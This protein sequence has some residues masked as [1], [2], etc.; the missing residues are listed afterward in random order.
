MIFRKQIHALVW[1][2]RHVSG[3]LKVPELSIIESFLSPESI[4][5]DVGAHGGSWSRALA[6]HASQR[7]VY[8]FEALPYYA[9]VLKMTMK[10]VGQGNLTILNRAVSETDGVV[11]MT[12]RDR[13]GNLLTGKTHVASREE[14]SQDSVS[15]PA[16]SLD[17]FW[18]EIGEKQ[19]DFI[20]CDVEGFELF[21]LR[22]ARYL[23][24]R[25]RPVFYN[26]LNLEWCKRYDYL[27]K[28]IFHL[29][30]G[31][32]YTPFYIEPGE[33]LIPVNTETHVNRDVLFV[34]KERP[35]P[36]QMLA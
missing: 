10:L 2:Y 34:P 11:R 6:R 29:F 8:A 24:E 13:K 27:P 19:V 18:R 32:G 26:E 3:R 23:I 7:R 31:Y 35:I 21:I 28:D 22:G 5:F 25:C 4:C 16:V 33:G 20:K 1:A 36:K 12:R 30:E 17:S 9:D 14:N 15:V